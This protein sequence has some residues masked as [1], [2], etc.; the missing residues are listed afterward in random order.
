MREALH[1]GISYRQGR[2]EA[3]RGEIDLTPEL[4]GFLKLY[5]C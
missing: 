2:T 4:D 5:E 3:L 1:A